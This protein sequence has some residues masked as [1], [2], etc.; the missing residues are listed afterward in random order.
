MGSNLVTAAVNKELVSGADVHSN[1]ILER[2]NH[3]DD[4]RNY[5]FDYHVYESKTRIWQY[6][7]FIVLNS[8]VLFLGVGTYI[9]SSWRIVAVFMI[10]VSGLFIILDLVALVRQIVKEKV[11]RLFAERYQLYQ[12]ELKTNNIFIVELLAMKLNQDVSTVTGDLK[13]AV[14]L[15]LIPEGHFG[16]SD[17]CFMIDDATYEKYKEHQIYY[18]RYYRSLLENQKKLGQ[19]NQEVQSIIALG[20]SYVQKIRECN[21]IIQDQTVSDKLDVMEKTV[22][23]IFHELDIHPDYY[24]DLHLLWDYY[25]PTTQKLLETYIELDESNLQTEY[26]VKTKEDIEKTLDIINNGYKEML[27]KFY[28][29]KHLDISSDISVIEQ[30]L[31]PQG[32]TEFT[33]EHFES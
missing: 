11:D 6:L 5:I 33:K 31:K 4:N 18:D 2:P 23:L 3:G 25:L 17:L 16:T 26:V 19:N 24:H 21:D 10:L 12:S 7:L 28:F 14:K 9:Y 13:K 22:D 8:V 1:L 27:E 15:K 29:E 32:K 20:K 30:M